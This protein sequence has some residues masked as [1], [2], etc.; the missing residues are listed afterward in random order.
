MAPPR[1]SPRLQDLDPETVARD[2]C[3]L[4]SDHLASLT[5]RVAPSCDPRLPTED[6]YA[7]GL[8]STVQHLTRYAQIG[9]C[10]DWTD[11]GCAADACLDV[12][13]ALYTCAGSTEIGGGPIDVAEEVEDN[14]AIGVVLLAAHARILLDQRQA[15]SPRL[16]APLSGVTPHQIRHLIRGGE[17]PADGVMVSAKD[18]RRWLK[19]RGVEGV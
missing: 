12:F 4:V 2:V 14:D 16:L 1:S 3:R 11:H 15:L 18:A 13:S 7:L 9:L 6:D 10:G 8:G 17:L 5:M 19:A